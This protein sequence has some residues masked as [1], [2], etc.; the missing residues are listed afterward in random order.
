MN[1]DDF[2][3]I[4]LW[5]FQTSWNQSTSSLTFA[6]GRTKQVQEVNWQ[7]KAMNLSGMADEYI[8]ALAKPC[9]E[10]MIASLTAHLE[11]AN[12]SVTGSSAWLHHSVL[13]VAGPGIRDPICNFS[14]TETI[15]SS[16][17]ERSVTKYAFQEGGVQ[18]VT[19]SHPRV[20]KEAFI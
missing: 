13:V 10:C 6:A 5:T 18:A 12:G 8:P 15:F 9:N 19:K 17:N 11:Y 20:K 3:E 2:T 14:S 7:S 4:A 1:I 16:G